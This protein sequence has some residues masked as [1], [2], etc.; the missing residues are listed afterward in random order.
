MSGDPKQAETVLEA[1]VRWSTTRPLWLRDALRR[2]VQKASISDAD[3]SELVA[4]CLVENG[5][6][7]GGTDAP[8]PV[9]LGSEDLPAYPAAAN[10]VTL[11]SV[12]EVLHV[13]QLAPNQTLNIAPAGLTVVYGD[14]GSGKSGYARI[15]K[16]ACRA[17]NRGDE[18][19]PNIYGNAGPRRTA[20]AQLNFKAGPTVKTLAWADG[21]KPTV[22]ELS[23]VSVFDAD[24]ASVHVEDRNDVAFKP[25]GLDV[26][27]RLASVSQRVRT[28]FEARR[29]A[30]EAEQDPIFQ[31]PT[32]SATSAVGRALSGLRHDTRYGDLA[33]PTPLS[34]EEARRL[35]QLREDLSKDP[36][37]AAREVR[38]RINRLNALVAHVA[39]VEAQLSD[40]TL[41]ELARLVADSRTK[42]EAA[43]VAAE[44]LF[45]GSPLAIGGDTWR[46][47]W[48]SARRY[49][50]NV[51][52]PTRPF[53][54][55]DPDGRCVLCQQPVSREAADRF[56]KL[57][58]FVK[59]DTERQARD[60]QDKAKAARDTLKQ[61][62]GG[63]RPCGQGLDEL[64]LLDPALAEDIRRF[65]VV[66]ALRKRSVLRAIDAKPDPAPP[67]A[68]ASPVKRLRERIQKEVERAVALEKASAEPARA[69]LLAE[70]TELQDRDSLSG[71]LP[72]LKA[73]IARLR[74]LDIF[75]KCI[76]AAN[77]K[78][79]TELG[80]SLAEQVLTPQLRDRFAEELISLAGSRVRAELTYAG[81]RTGSP[82]YQVRLIARPAANVARILSEGETTCVAL[83]G[84]LA[85]LATADHL[86]G[87][88]FDDPVCSLDHK[89]RLN[90]A[91]R[92]VKEAA[93]RQVLVFT[94]DIVFVH[95]L[96]DQAHEQ[97]VPCELRNLRR[98]STGTGVVG[99]GLPWTGMRIEQ[100]LDELGKRARAAKAA[101]EAHKEDEY[102]R[103]VEDIYSDLRA[104]WER[105]LE[106]VALQR[107]VVRHRDYIDTKELKKVSALSAADC[108]TFR[109]QFLTN[110]SMIYLTSGVGPV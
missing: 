47:L 73:E 80:N 55:K 88:I 53:P 84:F 24:C 10:A 7:L 22:P 85:E 99:D 39:T 92:L 72:K 8:K 70:R 61:A 98:D 69:K 79:I 41:H 45:A 44:Q 38:L 43:T 56:Q 78:P 100:R 20:S 4:I 52:Y 57:D 107:T 42:Q 48:E 74:K 91:R 96:H 90:V 64:S 1:I 71:L 40:A 105:A 62:R 34:E 46:E 60:A 17:R 76:A 14:N 103:E 87:L 68:P 95:D 104:T 50:E 81:G 19:E 5:L 21:P 65:V 110:Q 11:V 18:I 28:E 31:A 35:K 89:W 3:V 32:W 16:R 58:D 75:D 97:G 82:Q 51:A 37:T 101:F 109:K 106:E 29:R 15:L 67:P 63:T 93:T 36:A 25:F 12:S 13:N 49:S 66:A 108:E 23:A 54:V 26:P 33:K 102:R 77:T 6:K 83:A 2:V 30:V 59:A 27:E 94:H 86:S 9:V